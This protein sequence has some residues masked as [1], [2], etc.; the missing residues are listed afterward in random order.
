ME[1]KYCSETLKEIHAEGLECTLCKQSVHVKCLKRGSV[2]GG[3]PGDVFFQFTCFE[4]SLDDTEKFVRS[5]MTW[6]QTIVLVLFNLQ[7]RSQGLAKKGYFHWK[8]HIA[9]FID[10][11]WNFLFRKYFRQR[12][13]WWGTVSGSLSHYSP[14]FFKSGTILFNEPGWWTLTFP[15]LTPNVIVQ[16][17]NELMMEKQ[18]AKENHSFA[19][20]EMILK[21]ILKAKWYGTEEVLSALDFNINS[22]DLLPEIIIYDDTGKIESDNLALKQKKKNLLPTVES[23]EQKRKLIKTDNNK[24]S[25]KEDDITH[26][27]LKN[28]ETKN[29]NP[30]NQSVQISSNY[31]PRK[32]H[33]EKLVKQ[34]FTKFND[35]ACHYNT[36][37]SIA[38]NNKAM[39]LKTKIMGGLRLEPVLSPYSALYL[40]PYIKRDAEVNPP[41]LQLMAE[42]Q[43]K[44]NHKCLGWKLPPRDPVDYVYVQPEHIPAIN[45]LC[46]HFFWPGIDLTE[47]LQYP[48]FSCVALYKRLIVGFAFLV[49]DVKINE[50]YMSFI[51]TRPGWRNVGVA[52]FMLYH[53]IQT[54]VGKDITLHVA[55]D[56]SAL[57]LYQKFGFKVE[58]V[59]LDF[60]EKY[61]PLNYKDSRHAF[62]CRLER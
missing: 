14:Y 53:L 23:F 35:P 20:D 3:L 40:C 15:K 2:P 38:S 58:H 55:I 37:L 33:E 39:D 17:N 51:F 21:N 45:S 48:D 41:W 54:S 1:C 31:K 34:M 19:S 42:L 10:K 12:R 30:T 36:S 61:F 16:L 9:A 4:C 46:N 25:S 6:L 49:P 27:L 47:C 43:V 7:L 28:I 11:N 62:F 18:K 8:T 52:K 32:L 24:S 29:S 57:F 22:D 26:L 56:N 50:N 5:K 60:Y 59:V 44:V 13:K